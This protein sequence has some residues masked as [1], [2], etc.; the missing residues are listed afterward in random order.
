MPP[1]RGGTGETAV[2]GGGVLLG[3]SSVSGGGVLLGLPPAPRTGALLG[4]SP[5]PALAHHGLRAAAPSPVTRGAKESG[6]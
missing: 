3:L 6:R 2:S 5:A 1:A 4:L